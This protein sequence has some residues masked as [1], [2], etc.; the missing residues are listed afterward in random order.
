MFTYIKKNVLTQLAVL[1]PSIPFC[2][3]AKVLDALVPE[4]GEGAAATTAAAAAANR[5]RLGTAM[6]DRTKEFPMKI[7]RIEYVAILQVSECRECTIRNM[8]ITY[9]CLQ[10]VRTAVQIYT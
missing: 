10:T 2:N 9:F 5:V 1:F 4:V 3:I 7:D 6:L 8:N